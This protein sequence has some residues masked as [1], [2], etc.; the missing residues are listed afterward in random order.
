MLNQDGQLT[1]VDFSRA[2]RYV[3]VKGRQME[4]A[5]SL[6]NGSVFASNSQLR[7]LN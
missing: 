3:D 1:V 6:F 4:V 5:D 7:G 2:R